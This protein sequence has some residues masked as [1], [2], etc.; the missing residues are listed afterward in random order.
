MPP[1][2]GHQDAEGPG[3]LSSDTQDPAERGQELL[4]L[5][6]ARNLGVFLQVPPSQLKLSSSLT[7][8]Q[9]DPVLLAPNTGSR[10]AG[11]VLLPARAAGTCLGVLRHLGS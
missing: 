11:W 5:L 8:C 3:E 6:S 7:L 9:P 1:H 10:D 4:P 2:W